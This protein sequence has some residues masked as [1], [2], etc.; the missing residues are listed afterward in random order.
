MFNG[1]NIDR[2]KDKLYERQTDR[3]TGTE[4]DEHADQKQLSK[5]TQSQNR[6]RSQYSNKHLRT[7]C[8]SL[9]KKKK[10]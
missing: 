8:H 7:K 3:Q 1:L 2:S 6:Q 9:V 5:K 10:R 4:L